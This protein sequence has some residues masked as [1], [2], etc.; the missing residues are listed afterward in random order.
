MIR[1]HFSMVSGIFKLD[2]SEMY[3]LTLRVFFQQL[4]LSIT[5]KQLTDIHDSDLETL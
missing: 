3:Y 1:T 2:Y 5:D 4:I